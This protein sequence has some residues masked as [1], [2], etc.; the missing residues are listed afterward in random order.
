MFLKT[1]DFGEMMAIIMLIA[2]FISAIVVPI[3]IVRSLGATVHSKG[4]RPFVI[5]KGMKEKF[6]HPAFY[7]ALFLTCCGSHICPDGRSP[8]HSP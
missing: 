6:F 8:H 2:P 3:S 7:V 4:N 5:W 1:I